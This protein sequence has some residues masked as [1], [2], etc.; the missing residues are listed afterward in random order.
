MNMYRILAI[1]SLV[2][3]SG[4]SASKETKKNRPNFGQLIQFFGGNINCNGPKCP[5]YVQGLKDGLMSGDGCINVND[6]HIFFN[7]LDMDSPLITSEYTLTGVQEPVQVMYNYKPQVEY[8]CACDQAVLKALADT[9]I[10][11]YAENHPQS[12]P[13]MYYNAPEDHVTTFHNPLRRAFC[14]FTKKTK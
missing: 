1:G 6:K 2:L 11:L 9:R 14:Q 5:D 10:K 7:N 8:E 3:A 4:I 12:G 13:V